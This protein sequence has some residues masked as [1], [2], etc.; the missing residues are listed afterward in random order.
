METLIIDSA[1][2]LQKIAVYN[3]NTFY[4]DNNLYDIP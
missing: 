4:R 3:N 1:V 2:E